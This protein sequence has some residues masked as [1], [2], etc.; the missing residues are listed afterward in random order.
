MKNRVELIQKEVTNVF[1]QASGKNLGLVENGQP[2]KAA[3]RIF[4]VVA[5]VSDGGTITNAF[6]YIERKAEGITNFDKDKLSP[7]R[8]GV[9]TEVKLEYGT[10]VKADYAA[11]T[12][13]NAAPFVNY[14]ESAPAFILNTRITFSDDEKPLL[15]F[16]I[17]EIHNP[18]TTRSNDEGYRA[19][20]DLRMIESERALRLSLEVPKVAPNLNATKRHFVM[21]TFRVGES[22]KR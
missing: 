17:K 21:L 14:N 11:A 12:F 20:G 6:D 4:Y 22:V 1:A 19:L 9:I 8:N 3:D 10:L 2:R 18:N 15:D 16:P 13:L 5:E 7:G